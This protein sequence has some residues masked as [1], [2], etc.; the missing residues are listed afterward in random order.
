MKQD[1]DHFFFSF[2][3]SELGETSY[4]TFQKIFVWPKNQT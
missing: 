1:H 4:D 3:P 2:I